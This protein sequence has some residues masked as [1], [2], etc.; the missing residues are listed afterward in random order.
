MF[1]VGTSATSQEPPPIASSRRKG[2]PCTI[3]SQEKHDPLPTLRAR[4]RE[5][6]RTHREVPREGSR[7]AREGEGGRAEEE[8]GDTVGA[9]R[10]V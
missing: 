7:R 10:E 4:P 9:V 5:V 6:D 1:E 8:L 3:R 2:R